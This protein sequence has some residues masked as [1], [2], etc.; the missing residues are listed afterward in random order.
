MSRV[1]SL[2]LASATLACFYSCCTEAPPPQLKFSAIP[3]H[4]ATALRAKY[5]PFAKYLTE[6]LDVDVEYVASTD[7]AASV[8]MF[9]NDE[10]QFAWFG[11]LT[12]VQAREKVPG[13]Q[14]VAMGKKDAEFQSYFIVPKD[15]AIKTGT[16][17]PKDAAG[18]KFTFGSESSTSGRLMPEY[19]IR[20]ATGKPPEE[21]FSQ[22]N[23]SGSHDKTIDLVTKGVWEIGAVNFITYDKQVASG[24]LKK[25][26]C[27]IIW[28]TPKY[29]DYQFT[30]RPQLDQRF[31]EGFTTKLTKALIEMSPEMAAG[32]ARETMIPA[33]NADFADILA[34]AK[35]LG[36][37]R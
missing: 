3:D 20:D 22:V 2:L 19:F 24:E 31:G 4:D 1:L 6:K 14:A 13:A 11:G 17:F 8:A 29:A 25:E 33:N 7:Y 34:V 27:P 15:S 37:T 18:K 5:E 10:V 30:V 28:T 12:G 9:I 21:F 16:E 32:F 36:M 23:F 26:D 35:Q